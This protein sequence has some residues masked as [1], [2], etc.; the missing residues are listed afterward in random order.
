MSVDL[1]DVS[2]LIVLRLRT[3][4]QREESKMVLNKEP[5]QMP[6]ALASMCGL[7]LIPLMQRRKQD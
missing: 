7:S 2:A 6:C 5:R 1:R 4:N 3:Q